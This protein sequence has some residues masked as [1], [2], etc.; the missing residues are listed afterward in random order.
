MLG[1]C[2]R[3]CNAGW[4]PLGRDPW[5]SAWSK[6]YRVIGYT[7]GL[8]RGLESPE[9]A[10]IGGVLIGLVESIVSGYVGKAAGVPA[11]YVILIVVMFFRPY[12]FFGLEKIERV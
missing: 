3:G 2:W 10:I 11:T 5:I 4:D 1:D 9:G 8:H 6:S 12:G 7:S